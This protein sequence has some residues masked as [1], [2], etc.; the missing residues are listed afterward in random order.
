MDYPV[1][2]INMFLHALILVWEI[3]VCSIYS[4]SEGEAVSN[5]RT[6]FL[7]DINPNCTYKRAD[8][9]RLFIQAPSDSVFLSFP[10][11][12]ATSKRRK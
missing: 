12:T 11:F 3:R 2:S 4:S 1:E 9:S 6:R 7:R 5:K 8:S 10:C